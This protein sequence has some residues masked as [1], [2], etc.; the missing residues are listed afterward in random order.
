[1]AC[2][3]IQYPDG[4]RRSYQEN[5]NRAY[6]PGEQ[7]VDVDYFC[8]PHAIDNLQDWIVPEGL[9]VGNI[10]KSVTKAIGMKQCM[11]CKG[12]QHDYNKRGLEIQQRIKEHFWPVSNTD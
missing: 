9:L 6:V 2:V 11:A 3:I 7:V 10:I 8:D 12:R 5:E 1:M 4:T